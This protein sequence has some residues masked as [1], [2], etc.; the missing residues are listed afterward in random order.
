MGVTFGAEHGDIA[1]GS[2]NGV[3]EGDPQNSAGDELR[4]RGEDF[5]LRPTTWRRGFVGNLQP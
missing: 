5:D 2:E 3:V 1:D 4:G